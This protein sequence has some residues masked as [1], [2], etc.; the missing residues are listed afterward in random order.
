MASKNTIPAL[1]GEIFIEEERQISNVYEGILRAI[2]IGKNKAGEIANYLFSKKLIQ[3]ENSTMIQ[4]YFK[5][6]I[7][8]GIL[9]RV[10]IF[11]RGEYRY[12]LI[13]P[14]MKFYFYADEK[15]NFIEEATREKADLI[16]KEFTPRLI[17]SGI[18]KLFADKFGLRESIVESSDYNIDG[19]LL[20]FK[21]PEIALE[22]KWKKLKNE[23]I[24]R[25][26]ETLSK[27]QA[28]RKIL[29]VQDKTNVKSSLEV[30]DI[31]DLIE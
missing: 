19:V 7:N 3:K 14:L 29:F 23:D 27:I 21:K 10:F 30:M 20:K 18:R 26:E 5:N 6:L 17:E 1:I 28:K 16:L 8:F 22:I 2:S 13:S 25:A 15:Y 11:N 31:N 12:D 9:K 24:K 4:Q